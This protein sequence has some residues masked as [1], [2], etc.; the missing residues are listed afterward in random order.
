M[1]FKFYRQH[2]A[3]DCGPT[4]LK[5]VARHY[6]RTLDLEYLRSICYLN[7]EGV[8]ILSVSEAAE[9]IG[10]KTLML[11]STY[12]YLVDNVPL[13]CILHWN[14]SHFVLLLDIQEGG[15]MG[16]LRG[17]AERITIADPGH[18]VVTI[19]KATFMRGWASAAGQKGVLLAVEPSRHFY[20]T[21]VPTEHTQGFAFLRNYVQPY[22]R[23]LI[24][25]LLGMT[26][27]SLISL[28]F[29]F[30]TQSL[31]D[32]GINR[33][34]E[35]FVVLILLA[36]LLLLLGQLTVGIVRNWILLHMNT[37][38]SI[39]IISDFLLKLMRLPVRFFDSKSIGDI[40][41]RITDHHR[42]EVFLTGNSI[43]SVF[44]LVNLVV[45]SVVLGL[46]SLPILG[47]FAAGSLLMM[48]WALLFMRRRR[49]LDYLRFQGQRD[50]QD[51]LFEIIHGMQEIKLNH[52]ESYR[53]WE[54]EKVQVKL[55][56]LNNRTLA[57]DQAQDLGSFFF[58]Q[59]KNIIITYLAARQVIQHELTLG[60]MLSISYI[61]GQM[62]SPLEQ[63][64]HF[65]K[66][67]QDAKLSLDRLR[68]IHGRPDEEGPAVSDEQ[69]A[70]AALLAD[71]KTCRHGDIVLE[72]V[73]FRFEGP[74]S[75]LVLNDVSLV[76]PEGKVTAIV[77]TSGSGKT[78][79][80]KLL[81]KF[82]APNSGHIAIGKTDFT[83]LSPRWWRRQ[84][85]TV[86]Q[87]GYIFSDTIAR[88]IAMNSDEIDAAKVHYAVEVANIAEF[89]QG[90]P[91]R[92]TTKIGRSGN[93]LSGGQKQRLLIARAVYKDPR[94][95]FFDEATSA[96]DA[97]NESV[98][99]R[100]LN[101]FFHGRTVV[102]VAHRLSTVRHAD[103]IVVLDQGRVAEI[104]S[105]EELV[106]RRGRYFD[107]V[108]NQL[109][110]GN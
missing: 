74:S 59:A 42:I 101:E 4:C 100:N 11:K 12:Q 30:L 90:L 38:I 28:A 13:P 5:M 45:F 46:Y 99:M 60:M 19:D 102:V 58:N 34:N 24:Q 68:E 89:V 54:W 66:T 40:T 35:S 23:Y 27:G 22:Y 31:V 26:L 55:F 41:Q 78:T 71:Q 18:G 110:L 15:I 32:F 81:L 75:P 83:T 3:M 73:S 80:L 64:I 51:S 50:T 36:Q 108:R 72:N 33:Q 44:S 10:L 77:G 92:F 16:R 97:N 86:L 43:N 70:E 29:P 93:G 21:E 107:L 84:V 96:L 14:Q 103:Q 20:V 53:R 49:H 9:Q 82:Y 88:N 61:I 94:Y 105:H 91:L 17:Q 76:I 57:L 25:L 39:S 52:S 62:N 63:L 48:T 69:S 79:L 6:G 87:E 67:T 7:S 37:R 47:V 98:I 56:R 106:H 65:V 2:D 1:Q 109:E 104:G 85:G 95:L 8:S